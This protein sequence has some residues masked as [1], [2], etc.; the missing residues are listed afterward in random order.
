MRPNTCFEHITLGLALQYGTFYSRANPRE[1]KTVS[2]QPARDFA[3]SQVEIPFQ[4]RFPDFKKRERKMKRKK[5]RKEEE[6]KRRRKK[7]KE[8]KE[9]RRER[10]TRERERDAREKKGLSSSKSRRN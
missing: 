1:K 4:T 6:K 10:E 8:E 7:K 3:R 5:R 2:F 9:E